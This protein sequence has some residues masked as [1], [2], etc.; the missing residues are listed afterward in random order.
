MFYVTVGLYLSWS[1]LNKEL[2][3]N[4]NRRVVPSE[5]QH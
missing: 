2:G 1:V 5:F 4:E 3:V